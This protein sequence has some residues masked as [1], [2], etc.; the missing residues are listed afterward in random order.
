[1]NKYLTL[2]NQEHKIKDN[3]LKNIKLVPIKLYDKT[4]SE[5]EEKTYEFYQLLK[6]ELKEEQI[7][8]ALDSAYRSI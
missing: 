8:V 7:E 2:V 3:Y 1:M 5:I 6:Q 4:P